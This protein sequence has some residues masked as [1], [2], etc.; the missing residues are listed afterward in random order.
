M[1]WF[2]LFPVHQVHDFPG[3]KLGRRIRLGVG[4]NGSKK[5][6]TSIISDYFSSTPLI[7]V[8]HRQQ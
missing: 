3:V 7:D 1:R 6:T 5:A 4:R 8:L 2:K